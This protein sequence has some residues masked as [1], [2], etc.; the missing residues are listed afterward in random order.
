MKVPHR[1][2]MASH[3]IPESCAAHCEVRRALTGVRIGQPLSFERLFTNANAASNAKGNTALRV[4]RSPIPAPAGSE[5][6]ACAHAPCTA[7]EISRL[8]VGASTNVKR[9]DC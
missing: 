9:G 2:D 6:L 5:N 8:A 1:E 3:T 4:I 7:R